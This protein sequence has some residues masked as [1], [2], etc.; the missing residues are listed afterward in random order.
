MIRQPLVAQGDELARSGEFSKAI[1][2]FKHAEAI[3]PS[4]ATECRIG[5][6]YTRRELW[7]EAEIF[8]ARCKQHAT[9]ADP[10]PEWFADAEAQLAQKLTDTDAAPIEVHVEPAQP[11]AKIA[12]SSFPPD[13][14]FEPRTIHL[15][16]GTY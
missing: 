11:I 6:V 15:A 7:S 3:A 12:V 13:E 9:A 1:A 10:T 14:D 16:P 8:F 5:L 2:A 4:A